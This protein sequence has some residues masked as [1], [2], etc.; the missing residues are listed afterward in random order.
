MARVDQ[1]AWREERRLAAGHGEPAPSNVSDQR[2]QVRTDCWCCWCCCCVCGVHSSEQRLRPTASGA[3]VA[4][5]AAVVV[6]IKCSFEHRLGS[7]ACLNHELRS[8]EGGGRLRC[9]HL[10]NTPTPTP[11]TGPVGRERGMATS[12]YAAAISGDQRCFV[13]FSLSLT[14]PPR[15]THPPGRVGQTV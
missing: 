3:A 8:R 12:K 15:C 11:S 5:G 10:M 4:G 1:A 7:M 2:L 6:F 9:Q 14:S 13:L